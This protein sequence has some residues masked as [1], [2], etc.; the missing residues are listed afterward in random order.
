MP[1]YLK[2]TSSHSRPINAHSETVAS[3]P[4][5]RVPW[6]HCR[7]LI[8]ADG[9]YEWRPPAAQ[10]PQKRS[11]RKQPYWI[12]KQDHGLFWLGGL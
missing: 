1:S 3:K 4:F 12:R 11:A 9:F 2:D 8:P 5:F 6:R 10:G 7:C